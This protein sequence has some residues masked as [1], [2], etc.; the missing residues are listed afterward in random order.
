LGSIV[1]IGNTAGAGFATGL[2]K[3]LPKTVLLIC[4]VLNVLTL[5][6]FA[7]TNDFIV[8]MVSRALTGMFSIFFF[9]FFQVWAEAFGDET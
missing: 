6:Y 9:V 2:L 3:S 5:K 8:F 1:F 4:F 7:E